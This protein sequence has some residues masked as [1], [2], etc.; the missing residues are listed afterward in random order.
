MTWK[1]TA[2]PKEYGRKAIFISLARSLRLQQKCLRIF[3][4]LLW[5]M[6]KLICSAAIGIH[7]RLATALVSS[8]PPFTIQKI[9]KEKSSCP[10]YGQLDFF[11]LDTLI[12]FQ[13]IQFKIALIAHPCGII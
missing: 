12:N 7:I 5:T 13:N 9:Y 8:S 4:I 10:I 11:F 2:R 6:K 3:K 1:I